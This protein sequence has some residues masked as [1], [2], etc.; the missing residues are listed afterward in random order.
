MSESELLGLAPTLEFISNIS[1]EFMDFENYEVYTIEGL[2]EIH[3]EE[4]EEDT[5]VRLLCTN[6]Q[7]SILELYSKFESTIIKTQEEG[8]ENFLNFLLSVK[9][10]RKNKKFAIVKEKE[11]IK[12]VIFVYWRTQLVPL[13]ENL[14]NILEDKFIVNAADLKIGV[15][16]IGEPLPTIDSVDGNTTLNTLYSNIIDDIVYEFELD[17]S[18]FSI[19]DVDVTTLLKYENEIIYPGDPL[20]SGPI[21]SLFIYDNTNEVIYFGASITEVT[22]LELSGLMFNLKYLKQNES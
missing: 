13:A 18:K 19:S 20:I 17:A 1:S 22:S 12:T 2:P 14:T 7:E 21:D 11:E 3:I 15:G 9:Q 6:T 8:P 4:F 10:K 5:G 16:L